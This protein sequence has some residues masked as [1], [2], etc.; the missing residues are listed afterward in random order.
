VESRNGTTGVDSYSGTAGATHVFAESYL[1]TEQAFDVYLAHLSPQG[2][3]NMM[4]M[5]WLPPREMLRA[6]VSAVAALRRAGVAH[7]AEHIMMVTATRGNFTAMLV[8]KTP[9]TPDEQDRVAR[10]AGRS[11]FFFLSASP[12]TNARGSNLY[13]QFLQAG[14]YRRE[15]LL[16]AGYPFDIEPVPDDR[17]FFFKFSRWTH[18]FSDQPVVKASVPVLEYSLI[19]LTILIGVAAVAVV[20]LPLLFL[21]HRALRAP[22]AGRYAVYFAGIGIGYMA[23]EMAFLQE[24]GLFLGHPNYAVSVVLA[25]LLFSSGLGALA[26]ERVVN[27]L[28]EQ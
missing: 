20:A 3:L 15:R 24:F 10:W 4:R 22:H 27:A 18:V 1:Y 8:K 9:F 16:A 26:A 13:Q 7:P 19:A 14:D 2:I 25:A 17:P 23:V 12:G 11:P 28:R 6:L 5:E 21:E